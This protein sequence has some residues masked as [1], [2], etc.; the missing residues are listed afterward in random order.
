MYIITTLKFQNISAVWKE[1]QEKQNSIMLQFL[2]MEA[3]WDSFWLKKSKHIQ[4]QE[5]Y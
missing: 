1:T 2:E 5:H 4:L 3:I